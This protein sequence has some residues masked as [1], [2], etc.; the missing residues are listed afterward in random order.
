MIFLAGG[1][2]FYPNEILSGVYP[3]HIR[4]AQ[5]KL[6]ECVHSYKKRRI[7]NMENLS[8]CTILYLLRKL[9]KSDGQRLNNE[10]NT[11]AKIKG[12]TVT[13][14]KKVLGI[15]SELVVWFLI[16]SPF[17]IVC[18]RNARVNA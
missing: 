5:C 18:N 11:A 4:F 8:P 16:L 9:G 10:K 15:V 6:R 17:N 12:I 1:E 14:A 13:R 3:E 7:P 2:K